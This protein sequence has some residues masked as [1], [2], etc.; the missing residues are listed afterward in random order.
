MIIASSSSGILAR[1]CFSSEAYK[2]NS[3]FL[4]STKT[5][6]N[7]EGCFLY[8]NE[9]IIA[10]SPTDFPC[11]VAPATRMCGI[12]VRSTIKVSFEMFFPNA[13]GKSAVDSW[14][15]FEPIIERIETTSGFW[16]GTSIPIVPRPGIGAIIR[17][18]S[19]DKL[20][21]ISSSRFFIFAMRIPG[22]GTIS[23]NVMV[24]PMVAR[25]LVISIL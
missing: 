25:I 16:F 24:G 8:N 9:V 18:P 12:L 15:F 23:Y 2:F 17:I 11:P 7:C 14:N 19:A 5:N 20:S 21:A 10:F 3:T 4:G 6:F 13:I 22:A 1:K